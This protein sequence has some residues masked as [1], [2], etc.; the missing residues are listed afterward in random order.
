MKTPLRKTGKILSPKS[1]HARIIGRIVGVGIAAIGLA[2]TYNFRVSPGDRI[3]WALLGIRSLFPFGPLLLTIGAFLI[4]YR[5]PVARV[6]GSNNLLWFGCSLI[7][8]PV[9]LFGFLIA[10]R[11]EILGFFWFLSLIFLGLPGLVIVAIGLWPTLRQI[12]YVLARLIKW[13]WIHL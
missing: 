1:R 5:R 9:L 8:V 12:L 4:F 13:A 11:S 7:A 2:E 10:S 6:R 3:G